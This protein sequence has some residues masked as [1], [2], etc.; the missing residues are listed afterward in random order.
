MG[1][2][3]GMCAQLEVPDGRGPWTLWGLDAVSCYYISTLFWSILIQNG[4]QK[5]SRSNSV[6][7]GGGAVPVHSSVH[8]L[9]LHS[10]DINAFI[11]SNC[12]AHVHY[13]TSLNQYWLNFESFKWI[14][15]KVSYI[16]PARLTSNLDAARECCHGRLQAPCVV[17]WWSGIDRSF[18]SRPRC[19]FL[20]ARI[21]IFPVPWINL[22]DRCAYHIP[23]WH[24]SLTAESVFLSSYLHRYYIFFYS[25]LFPWVF[26]Y[27]FSYIFED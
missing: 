3:G 1:G 2:G 25:Y 12:S 8:C 20:A 24:W 22:V 19:G 16:L 26:V 15:T 11:S 17:F 21:P 4:I 23:P 18:R 13:L 14:M 6:G 27:W 9:G 5:H 10:K 7:G